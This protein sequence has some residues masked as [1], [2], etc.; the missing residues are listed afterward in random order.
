M[1]MP[2]KVVFEE[3]PPEGLSL[4]IDDQSW[5]PHDELVCVEPVW[6]RVFLERREKRVFFEGELRATARLDCDRCLEPFVYRLEETFHIDIE[7][8][9]PAV[10]EET[11]LDYDAGDMDVVYVEEPVIDVFQLLRQQV[12][13]LLPFKNLCSEDCPGLCPNC[14]ALLKRGACGCSQEA[15]ASSESPLA[16]LSELLKARKG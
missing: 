12:F 10:E 5:F 1:V 6:A 9:E 3:I 16:V 2:L 13:L 4:R 8:H 11:V 7:L 15:E 14:G